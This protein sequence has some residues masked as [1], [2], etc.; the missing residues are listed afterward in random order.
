MHSYNNLKGQQRLY[1][2]G[3]SVNKYYIE[4]FQ[5]ANSQPSKNAL[6]AMKRVYGEHWQKDLKVTQK[7]LKEIAMWQN[8]YQEMLE[9]KKK[10]LKVLKEMIEEKKMIEEKQ[11]NYLKRLQIIRGL[12]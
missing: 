10:N 5:R 11:K 4:R 3:A 6:D 1:P 12:L 9:E 8:Q 2:V 7:Y